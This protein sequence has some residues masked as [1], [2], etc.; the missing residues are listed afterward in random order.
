LYTSGNLLHWVN[1][2]RQSLRGGD[3]PR[4]WGIEM[5][6]YHW[7]RS[8]FT[9]ILA[10]SAA[11]AQAGVYSFGGACASLGSWSQAALTQTQ[12]IIQVVET[13][14]DN[15][16]CKG[17][18]SIIPK[19]RI[20]Q[21]QLDSAPGEEQR[22]DRIE[23]IPTEISALRNVAVSSPELKTDVLKLLASRTMEGASLAA[24]AGPLA[25]AGPVGVAIVGA[26]QLQTRVRRASLSGLEM[27]NQ[28][29]A[30]LPSYD[31]C[32][33]GRP[34]QGLAML[35]AAVKLT[36][37][38]ASSEDGVASKMGDSI[39]NLVTMLRNR[40]FTKALRN[41]D[42]T[43]FWLSMS[44]LM[45]TTSQSYCAARDARTVLNYGMTQMQNT[46]SSGQPGNPLEG[47][48]VLSRD[49]P[50]VSD[51]LL[52]IQFGI[53]PKLSS[54]AAFKNKVWADVTSLITETN[55]LRG[56]YSEQM[57]TYS[58][59]QDIPSKQAS[60]MKLIRNLTGR[61]LGNVEA[62]EANM[63]FFTMTIIE[64]MI[65]FKLIG[66][67][68]IPPEC[69][70]NEEG[71]FI[72][73]W[74]V[75]M[76]NGGKFQPQFND[77]DALAKVIGQQ[78]EALISSALTKASLYFQQRM[79]VDMPNLVSESVT[80]QTVTVVQ[81][82]AQIERYL[83]SL[84]KKIID[85][86]DDVILIPNIRNTRARVLRVLKSYQ[87][88]RDIVTKLPADPEQDSALEEE[89]REAYKK[90]IETA[91]EQF[92]ILLQKDTFLSTRLSTFIHYDYAMRIKKGEDMSRYE[93]DVLKVSGKDLLTRI[94][95]ITNAN[96]TMAMNDLAAAQVVNKRNLRDIEQ[97][98][99]DSLHPVI[100]ELDG[101][102][103][104][105]NPGS[106][107]RQMIHASRTFRDS[108]RHS[109]NGVTDPF[110]LGLGYLWAFHTTAATHARQ[111]LPAY[112]NFLWSA[113]FPMFSVH[114]QKKAF[115]RSDDEF[116]SFDQFR[117]KLCTQTLAFE[118][119][120]YFAQVCKGAVLRS[121]F[122]LAGQSR[123][124]GFELDVA[125][126]RY[127]NENTRFAPVKSD[128][129]CAFQNYSRRNLVYWLTLDLEKPAAN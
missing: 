90:I 128:S 59:L 27:L 5:N 42:E 69:A 31:R 63:N 62:A 50:N 105:Y 80:S 41:L 116:G 11:S 83:A 91:Y 124:T 46:M 104:G 65:P 74:D 15:P 84:E 73:P 6:A 110:Q 13:L 30:V 81:S 56:L 55:A 14:K 17:I 12:T 61:L 22:V 40:K 53:T 23:S 114:T 51:W 126:D 29:M 54:D 47:Y 121:A 89:I 97:L 57:L 127:L 95:Q 123:A 119:R 111:I 48:Y 21:E 1:P 125:Y 86:K 78:L 9:L 26:Q 87:A 129:I 32:L 58:T 98:F 101:I 94:L 82:L 3:W 99:R 16:D 28:A 44:C 34:S 112:R 72:M 33:I 36:A 120:K 71:K 77:P 107:G 88:V 64:E 4:P 35:G 93:E 60:L 7:S 25:A 37:A 102:V 100:S 67:D 79:I 18:E 49:I 96:P 122:D 76:Q 45:E 66:L 19:I 109:A 75:W 43:Q 10:L 20:A 113:Y 38:F 24:E 39:A 8:I 117:A 115:A 103:K 92:N 68:V 52:K 70:S 2:L 85:S 108:F 118:D 106:L